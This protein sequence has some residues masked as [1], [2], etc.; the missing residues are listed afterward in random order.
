MKTITDP[1]ISE[2]TLKQNRL[3]R[4]PGSIKAWVGLVGYLI[5]VKYIL[6]LLPPFNIKVIASEFAWST[7]ILYS[8]IGVVGVLL[9]MVTGFPDALDKA[10]SNRR[11]FVIPVTAGAG[12]GVLAIVID[13]FTHGTKFLEM[14]SGEA[15]F[16][17]Y[18]PASLFVY[19]GGIVL[20]EAIFR[21][22]AIPLFLWLISN[23]IL[24][25]HGQHQTFWI[26]AFVLS[27]IEPVTQGLG[28]IF[29]KSS[30]DP[31]MLLSTQFLPYFITD[32]PLN[33]GQAIFF[34]KYGFLASF[35][36][37]LGFYIMWHI[38]YGNFIYPALG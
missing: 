13:Q 32:Y 2:T 17:V 29:L 31:V 4:I 16:N 27:L 24:R 10:I 8:V 35:A 14:Q 26:L 30:A 9:S 7:I 22:L 15:S 34:R 36:M 12:L 6:T 37:R 25:G 19:T 18:F 28:I 21:I 20:V 5:L 3:A 33:L 11:R 1:S 23:L 38:V